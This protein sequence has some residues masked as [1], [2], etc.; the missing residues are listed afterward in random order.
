[1]IKLTKA[2]RALGLD[3]PYGPGAVKLGLGGESPK[4]PSEMA[5]PADPTEPP[6][7]PAPEMTEEGAAQPEPHAAEVI[8]DDLPF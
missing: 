4:R 3:K 7:T 8:L 6:E 1:M 2:R 5:E